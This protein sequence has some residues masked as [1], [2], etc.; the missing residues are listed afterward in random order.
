M[1]IFFL[2]VGHLSICFLALGD[3]IGDGSHLWV[4]KGGRSFIHDVWMEAVTVCC[5]NVFLQFLHCSGKF[6]RFSW[7]KVKNIAFQVSVTSLEVS[8]SFGLQEWFILRFLA[9]LLLGR[10]GFSLVPVS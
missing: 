9:S 8:V 10:G 4:R 7:S 5:S 6:V 2:K 3:Q 1:S